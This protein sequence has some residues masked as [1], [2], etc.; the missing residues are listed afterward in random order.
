MGEA[1]FGLIDGVLSTH[2]GWIGKVEV[3]KVEYDPRVVSFEKLLDHAQKRDCAINVFTRTD[4]HQKVAARAIGKRAV[5]SDAALRGVKD[6]KYY[7]SR[8]A[9]KYLPMTR[10]QSARVNA[11]VKEARKWLSP[12][13]LALLGRIEKTPDAGWKDAIHVEFT[14]A[15]KALPGSSR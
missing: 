15:W 10:A 5:R 7:A 2:P 8:S 6:N 13:Q 1:E 9:L 14:A 3:V 4:A 11:R 12:R